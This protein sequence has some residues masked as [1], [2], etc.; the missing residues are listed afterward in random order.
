MANWGRKVKVK[1]PCCKQAVMLIVGKVNRAKK[2]GY[3]IFCSRACS[4]EA[5]RLHKGDEQKK[6]EKR[7]YDMEYRTKNNSMLRAKKAQDFQNRSQARRDYEVEYRK[8]N[9]KYHVEYCR[10]EDYRAWK[11]E[12]DRQY[13]AKNLHGEFWEAYLLLLDIDNAVNTRISDYEVRVINGTINKQLQR[14]RAYE[15]IISLKSQNCPLGSA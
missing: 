7:L 4:S 14:K 13:R 2:E 10:D 8:K 3:K 12:Y 9:M 11:K 6:L 5:R 1:C 15:R